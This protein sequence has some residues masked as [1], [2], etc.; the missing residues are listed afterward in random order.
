MSEK[1][2]SCIILSG[3]MS[4]RM[5]EDKGSMIIQGKPMILHILE[6][7]NGKINDAVIVLNNQERINSY[8]E[9]LNAY[10][11]VKIEENF[12]YS[13][14]FIEDEVKDKGPVAGIM[15]GLKNIKT[16]YA[17]VLPCDSPFISE[18]NIKTMFDLLESSEN[19][20]AVIPY[21]TKANKDRLKNKREFNFK[22]SSEMSR[23]MKIENSEPLHSI[24]KKDNLDI[25]SKL[26]EDDNLYVKSFIKNLKCVNFVEVDNEV[27]FEDDFKNFNR[28]EDIESFE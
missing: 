7:L 18:D 22:S 21:H 19:T 27:L 5:G 28:K 15:T 12:T 8:N 13:L 4:R 11:P 20:D 25:I 23:Y 6:R 14:E 16:D 24:Y 26:L 9:L 10:V 3:G 1:L 2:Y 17:L